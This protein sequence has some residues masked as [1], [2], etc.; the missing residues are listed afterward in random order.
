M[1]ALRSWFT[2]RCFII[3]TFHSMI[4]ETFMSLIK[5]LFLFRLGI[6]GGV[7]HVRS[8]T[9]R[10]FIFSQEEPVCFILNFLFF[11]VHHFHIITFFAGIALRQLASIFRDQSRSIYTFCWRKESIIGPAFTLPDWTATR[12]SKNPAHYTSSTSVQK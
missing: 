1:F 3:P 6:H 11:K 4:F 5:C 12:Y 7:E 9:M 10:N 2:V 8:A